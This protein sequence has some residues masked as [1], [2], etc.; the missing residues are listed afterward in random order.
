MFDSPEW[1]ALC[2]AVVQQPA[3]DL[4]RLMA[5][6]WLEERGQP[7]RAEFIRVQVELASDPTPALQWRERALWNGVNVGHFWPIELAPSLLAVRFDWSSPN[8]GLGSSRSTGKQIEFHRGFPDSVNTQAMQWLQFGNELVPQYPVRTVRLQ[9]C[10]VLNQHEWW[11]LPKTLTGV[12]VLH[13]NRRLQLANELLKS[14]ADAGLRVVMPGDVAMQP[15][16]AAT[17]HRPMPTAQGG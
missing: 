17:E 9:T 3:D 6:D 15:W 10:E 8:S 11:T 2:Q 5:A 12:K 1:L 13:V 7:E 4:P 16:P 14:F